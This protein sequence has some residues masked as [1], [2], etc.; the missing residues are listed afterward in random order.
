MLP[1]KFLSGVCLFYE[2][3]TWISNGQ[4]ADAVV[5]V[6]KTKK[7]ARA[8][9]ALSLFIVERGMPGF[10]RGKNLHKIGLKAQVNPCT[11]V[12]ILHLSIYLPACLL[13]YL[14]VYLP[15]C[16]STYLPACLPAYLSL[17]LVVIMSI[18]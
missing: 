5:V 7:E 15:T 9:H 16:L 18:N 11:N 2:F 1:R 3:Q 8:A 17:S 4:L 14:P 6:A 12:C 10:E 13:T